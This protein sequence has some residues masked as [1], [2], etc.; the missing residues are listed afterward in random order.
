MDPTSSAHMGRVEEEEEMTCPDMIAFWHW[1]GDEIVRQITDSVNQGFAEQG[2]KWRLVDVGLHCNR[3]L[4]CDHTWEQQG[5]PS[6][7]PGCAASW[8]WIA[9][10]HWYIP[11]GDRPP[12]LHVTEPI[13]CDE[14]ECTISIAG[15]DDK[16]TP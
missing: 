4:K 13:Q 8:N 7:C 2:E 6:T 9:S 15:Y 10:A 1:I 5:P 14:G 16:E 11:P 3:C 12:V